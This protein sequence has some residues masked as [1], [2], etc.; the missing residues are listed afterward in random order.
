MLWIGTL[1]GGVN[2]LNLRAKKFELY[3]NA[4]WQENS[5][6]S[7]Q[8]ITFYEDENRLLWIG[9][10]GGGINVLDRKTSKMRHLNQSEDD[11]LHKANVSSFF[12]DRNGRLWIG[13][14]H[15]LYILDQNDQVTILNGKTIEY[16]VLLPDISIEKIIEDYDGHLWFSTTNGLVEY[17]PGIDDFYNGDFVH[18][19]HDKFNPNTLSDNF[20]RDIYA[21]P[22]PIDGAK[23]IWVGTRNGLNRMSFIVN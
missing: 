23:V 20:I 19:Y 1:G 7:D 3:Q 2:K 14:W 9:L 4:P 5:I 11:R 10:R 12:K 21:E 18:Y 8:V 17:V 22:E 15:G 6:S 16:D 13:T